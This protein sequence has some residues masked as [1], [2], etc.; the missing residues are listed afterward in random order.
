MRRW[1]MVFVLVFGLIASPASVWAQ[2][3]KKTAPTQA[4]GK[5]AKSTPQKKAD[6]KEKAPTATVPMAKIQPART[7]EPGISKH[8]PDDVFL[9]GAIQ[10]SKL[11]NAKLLRESI[12]KAGGDDI[13]NDLLE[14]ATKELVLNPS[15]I[16]ELGFFVD[17]QTLEKMRTEFAESQKR[18][19]ARNMIKQLG[20]SMH[21]FH[22][23]YQSFPN[24]DGFEESKGNLSWRVHMLPFLEEAELYQ[25]FH[26]DEPWDSEHNKALIKRMPDAFK[27]D[28]VKDPGKTSIHVLTGPGMPF[29][30]EEPISFRDVTDGTS[31]TIMTVL[32]GPTR[33]KCGP[34]PA[35]SKSIPKIL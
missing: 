7:T 34:G 24:S 32:A 17:N 2:Q 25:E 6:G 9:V 19:K 35:A 27:V 10:P 18:V 23:T 4:G 28:G 15:K 12:S 31:N 14:Q 11:I 29:G 26:L 30:G 33:L 22:D 13:V 5:G 21:N 20:L 16:V 3:T 8:I 1:M